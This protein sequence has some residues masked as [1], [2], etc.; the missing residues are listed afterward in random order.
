MGGE[1]LVADA[2][3]LELDSADNCKEE[4]REEQQQADQLRDFL[5][6]AVRCKWDG[7]RLD[8]V[9]EAMLN[10]ALTVDRLVSTAAL[11]SGATVLFAA[12]DLETVEL[13]RG[14]RL[15]LI[16]AASNC[17]GPIDPLASTETSGS[18]V[19]TDSKISAEKFKVGASALQFT[20]MVP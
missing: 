17:V 7:D 13:K 9:V 14:E 15:D 16:A 6:S 12:L 18:T 8:L 20:P 5:K 2:G 1:V 3:H 11:K 19:G 10:E 4:R